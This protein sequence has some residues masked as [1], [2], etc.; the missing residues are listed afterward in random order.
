MTFFALRIE[1]IALINVVAV[2]AWI[3]VGIAVFRRHKALSAAQE[4]NR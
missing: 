2:A 3:A 4:A 1:T